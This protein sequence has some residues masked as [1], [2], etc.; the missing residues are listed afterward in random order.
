[1][2]R[3]NERSI[4][5]DRRSEALQVGEARIAGAEIVDREVDADRL[6]SL[7]GWRSTLPALCITMLSVIS[8]SRCSGRSPVSDRMRATDAHQALLAE[9]ARRQVDRHDD[10]RQPAR[11]ATPGSGAHAVRS[12]HSPIWHDEAGLLGERD[13][14]VGRDQAPLRVLPAHQR[15]DRRRCAPVCRFTLRL[16]VQQELVALQRAAQARAPCAER[17]LTSWFISAV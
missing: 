4:L 1:M 14:A 9:L 5:S 11:P 12:T 13:E 7:A 15:L 17:S 2:S 10:R 3:T 8:S 16:V 6:Q